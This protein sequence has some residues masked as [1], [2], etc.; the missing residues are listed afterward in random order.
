MPAGIQSWFQRFHVALD[1]EFVWLG[2]PG[3]ISIFW[4]KFCMSLHLAP[5][6]TYSRRWSLRMADAPHW[7]I[8]NHLIL[9]LNDNANQ[10]CS[11]RVRLCV[12]T[13]DDYATR[14]ITSRNN[15]ST[16]NVAS[17]RYVFFMKA[18]KKCKKWARADNATWSISQ[19]AKRENAL[20]HAFNAHFYFPSLAQL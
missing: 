10:K 17:D 12:S 1:P 15:F 9:V 18:S 5:Q 14:K 2:R 3:A 7:H 11:E 8:E 13:T 6:K 16:Q 4:Q 20:E 19:D